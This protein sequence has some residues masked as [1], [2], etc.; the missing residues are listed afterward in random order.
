MTNRSTRRARIALFVV[1]AVLVLPAVLPTSRAQGTRVLL[2]EIDGAI[3]RTTVD[4]VSEAVDEAQS[5]GYAALVVRFDTPGGELDATLAIAKLMDNAKSVP[6]LGWVGPVG[7]H[8]FSAGTILLESTDLAAMS[9]GTTIGSV[10]PVVLGPGGFEPITD[11]KIVNAVIGILQEQMALHDRNRN[12][13][14]GGQ[15]MTLAEWFVLENLNLNA[16]QAQT[17]QATEIV[18]SSVEDFLG[19]ADGQTTFYKGIHLAVAGAAVDT[20]TPSARVSFLALLSNPL[21]SSLLL[22]LGVYLVIFGISAPGHG[23]EIAGII[24]LLLALIGLGFSVDPIALFL[25]V[26][27]VVLIILEL[28]APGFGAFGIGGIIA[29]VLGAVFL[30]PLRPPRFFVTPEYQLIFLVALLVPTGAFGGFMLFALYKVME[31]RRRKPTVGVMV[32]E[33]AAAVDPIRAGERGY[34]MFHGEL[35]Q[36]I[37]AEDLAPEQKVYIRSVDGILLHVS[38]SPPP[39]PLREAGPMGFFRRLFR[40]KPA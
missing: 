39:A 9:I 25:I 21:V 26:I 16:T 24:L 13:T 20:F 2:A 1:L 32:G 31:V 5:G 29:I 28:K 3:D 27:G 23:A 17:Y 14:I 10:Q 12:V 36:A 35:W 18:A 37:P 19:Q 34:V 30:A 6:I 7:A 15:T 22:I 38:T 11:P 4:Y 33:T 8:A 40:R